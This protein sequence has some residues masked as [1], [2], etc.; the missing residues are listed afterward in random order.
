[1]GLKECK[2]IYNALSI[3]KK[4]KAIK[5]LKK[6][7]YKKDILKLRKLIKKDPVGWFGLYHHG[8]GTA[9]R[10]ALRHNGFG[11]EYFGIRNLDDIYVELVEDAV[12][13]E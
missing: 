2:I 3:K 7:I 12:V 10:N 1:M 8:W 9:I 5:F 4:E 13:K 6:W 11:E